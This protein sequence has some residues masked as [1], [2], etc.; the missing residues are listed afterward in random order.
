MAKSHVAVATCSRTSRFIGYVQRVSR[1]HDAST[2]HD[3]SMKRKKVIAAT[4]ALALLAACSKQPQPESA[5]T[6]SSTTE[7]ASEL[8]APSADVLRAEITAAG[9]PAEYAAHFSA[10]QLTRIV[11]NRQTTSGTTTG[12]Y[13]FQGARLIRY[14]GAALNRTSQ[15]DLRFDMQG[16]LQPGEGSQASDED[17]K[18]IRSRAQLLRNHALAQRTTRTHAH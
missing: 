9:V 11:E 10:Q 8:P 17:L 12:E 1:T 14:R 15:L 13:E 7:S 18:A 16:V 6:P 5:P 4:V 3:L 2:T